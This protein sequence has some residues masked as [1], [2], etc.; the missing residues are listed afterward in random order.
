MYEEDAVALLG[1]FLFRYDQMRQRSARSG[2][3][4]TRLQLCLLMLS[5]ANCLLLD[6]P[7]NHLDIDSMEVLEAALESYDGTVIVISHDRYLLDRIPD[8]IVE[9]RDGQALA[10]R[11]L[12][13]LARSTAFR[14]GMSE[15]ALAA[16]AAEVASCRAC[17][18]LVEWRN[19]SPA[20]RSPGS[21]P[22]LLGKARPGFGDAEARVL[23][24]GLAPAAHG[25]NRTGRIFTGNSPATSCS[26]PCMARGSEPAHER[27]RRRRP[28][29]DRRLRRSGRS[30]RAARQQAHARGARPV[31]ALPRAGDR[32][33]RAAAGDRGAGI[34][35]V[36]RC[37]PGPRRPRA[38]R[39]S[40]AAIRSRSRGGDRSDH[41]DRVLPSEPTEHLHRQ[42][43]DADDGIGLPTRRL[44]R[45]CLAR[46]STGARRVPSTTIRGDPHEGH[47]HPDRRVGRGDDRRRG[48]RRIGDDGT[49]R[50]R[51]GGCDI[52]G[53]AGNDLLIG[54]PTSD[55][56]CGLEVT[57][58]SAG[59]TGTTRS[60]AAPAPITSTAVGVSTSSTGAPA[61]I[62]CWVRPPTTTSRGLRRGHRVRRNRHRR[63]PWRR[64][65]R[66]VAGRRERP[67]LRVRGRQRPLPRVLDGEETTRSAAGRGSIRTVPTTTTRRLGRTAPALHRGQPVS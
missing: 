17:P 58:A 43:H 47:P 61:T 12:R 55:R 5:G 21:R 25:G 65:R 39:P 14:V 49:T 64:R 15:E 51:E 52:V 57:I 59:G 27:L 34:V 26:R 23:V 10:S 6:E 40:E 24:V 44:A 3:E 42:A 62:V 31:P 20:R 9:V 46:T 50:D 56:I 13:R 33:A 48:G 4:R 8:R 66:P 32:G 28:P 60:R 18:R 63:A 11:W 67:R 2:G 29:A 54:T 7:T 30:M 36:G 37:D 53:T 1:R 19:W 35:R 41:A 38:C 16:I 22:D 45:R